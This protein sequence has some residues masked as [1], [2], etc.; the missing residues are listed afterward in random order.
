MKQG[1][2]SGGEKAPSTIAGSKSAPFDHT[3]VRS[4]HATVAAA[5]RVHGKDLVPVVYQQGAEILFNLVNALE[6]LPE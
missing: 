5:D 1:P 2:S 6:C 3:R 4:C